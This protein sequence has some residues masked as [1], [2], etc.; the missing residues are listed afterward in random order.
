MR[1]ISILIP[2]LNAGR[3]LRTC[4][5][6]IAA[7]D[8]PRASLEI[9]VADGGSTDD[10]LAIARAYDAKIVPNLLKTGEAG[11]AA[12]LKQATGEIVAFVDSDNILPQP[13]WLRRMTEPFGDSEI[14][15][16]EPIE[17]T[18]RREDGYITRYGALMGM[19]DPLCLFLGNYDR[20]NTLTGKWTEMPVEVQDRGSYLKVTLDGKRLP[21]IGANGFLVRRDALV[22]CSVQDY[23]FDIDAVYELLQQ[24]RCRFAKVKVG[25]VHLFSG[26]VRTYV[27]KQMRRVNDYFYYNRSGLRRYP[28]KNTPRGGVARF[29]LYTVTMLPVLVQSLI[30]YRRRPDR[31]W[32]FHPLACWATLAVYAY[33]TLRS[34]FVLRPQDRNGWSQ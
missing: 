14:V 28:W 6:S 33:G 1:T 15:G 19:I 23:V 30:G 12:A 4:L 29:I 7:Q 21:T 8:Y 34:R 25:I 3:V 18:W 9:V 31:A 5:E 20:Y 2:T 24:G 16:A 27:R 26:D 32:F 22:G 10:T 17:Y 11:K 13:D